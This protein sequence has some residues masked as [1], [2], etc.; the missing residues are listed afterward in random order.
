M[1]LLVRIELLKL[2]TMRLTY[3]LAAAVAVLTTLFALLENGQAGRPP[4]VSPPSPPP[5][6]CAP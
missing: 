6:D 4:L 2:K 3:G 1:T 5:K